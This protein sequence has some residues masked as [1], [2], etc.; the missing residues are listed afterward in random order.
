MAETWRDALDDHLI[1]LTDRLPT[2][3]DDVIRR[4]KRH[5]SNEE[6]CSLKSIG[7]PAEKIETLMDAI[8]ARTAQH[9]N[10]F[11]D[12]LVAVKQK[13]LAEKLS[14]SLSIKLHTY[15]NI[16]VIAITIQYF[17]V[18]P[19]IIILSVCDLMALCHNVSKNDQEKKGILLYHCVPVKPMKDK[20]KMMQDCC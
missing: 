14:E 15:V 7:N 12:A 2:V 8:R 6:Y 4:M 16:L 5:I 3:I 19:N 1:E 18:L 17:A 9:F 10:A 11:C 20:Q 13:D